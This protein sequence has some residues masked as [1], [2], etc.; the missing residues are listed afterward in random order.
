MKRG[1]GQQQTHETYEESIKKLGSFATVHC[2]PFLHFSTRSSLFVYKTGIYFFGYSLSIFWLRSDRAKFFFANSPFVEVVDDLHCR[3]C[4][5]PYRTFQVEGFW[6]IY[7]HT[8]RAG[9]APFPVDLF[10]FR[11]GIKPLWEVCSTVFPCTV[12]HLPHL[13]LFA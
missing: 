6:A 3:P 10:C 13:P 9:D 8:I 11:E 2:S 12:M 4:F 5:A 1:Q 7:N